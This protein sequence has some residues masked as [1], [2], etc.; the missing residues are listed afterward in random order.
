MYIKL[1][2]SVVLVTTLVAPARAADDPAAKAEALLK[3]WRDKGMALDC[4]DLRAVVPEAGMRMDTTAPG[5]PTPHFRTATRSQWNGMCKLF[6]EDMIVEG[7]FAGPPFCKKT[8][9]ATAFCTLMTATSQ[10]KVLSFRLAAD[11]PEGV[12][13]ERIE[14]QRRNEEKE[15]S[16]DDD[17]PM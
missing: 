7:F 3:T 12:V 5:Y 1:I 8:G 16:D 10:P 9:D 11:R 2:L 15:P 6:V 13:L 4:L 17:L 14:W